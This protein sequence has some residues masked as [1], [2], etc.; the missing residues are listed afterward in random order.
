VRMRGEIHIIVMSLSHF[1]KYF[2]FKFFLKC[3]LHKL[4]QNVFKDVTRGRPV[5]ELL[6]EVKFQ[7]DAKI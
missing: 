1:M 5:Y 7:Q 2:F 6:N 3:L 4:K